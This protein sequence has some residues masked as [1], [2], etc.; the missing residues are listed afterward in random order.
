MTEPEP[1]EQRIA[2]KAEAPDAVRVLL[3]DLF[4]AF[5]QAREAARGWEV[6][7]KSKQRVIAR[8][9]KEIAQLKADARK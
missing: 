2:D 3:A 8:Q 7:G 4:E 1:F 9:A 6:S 5:K